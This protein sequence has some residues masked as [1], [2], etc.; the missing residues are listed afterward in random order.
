[1]PST[2]RQIFVRRRIA[3]FGGLALILGTGLYLPFTL[4]APLQPVAAQAV[5]FTAPEQAVP[6]LDF[7]GFG[8]AG[9]GAV[10]YPGVL[11][12]SGPTTPLPIASITKVITALVVLDA[13]P[14]AVDEA[15]PGVTFSAIDT[16]YY[17]TSL[18][19]EGIVKPVHAGQVTSERDVLNLVLMASASNYARSLA[20]WAFDTDEA[21]LTAA[22]AWLDRQGLDET[23]IAGPTGIEPTNT[24]T[25]AD[26]LRLAKIALRHPVVAQIVATA[27][28][29]IA[30]VGGVANR[31]QLLGIDGVDGIKTGTLDEAGSC[32]LFS[33]DATVG[34]QTISLVGV[35]LGGPD[36][37]TVDASVRVLLEQAVAGFQE[38]T[39]AKA[40]ESFATYTTSWGDSSSAVAANNASVVVWSDTPV[41]REVDTLDVG[42]AKAGSDAGQLTFRVGNR[43]IRV[44]LRLSTTIDDPG[45]WW[46]LTN[47]GSMF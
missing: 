3:V 13:K 43:T 22:R 38:V 10:G 25:V 17:R 24:S 35:V 40:G 6:V 15:G 44:P 19:E 5:P 32:L 28:V 37:P 41:A 36:H 42:I 39:L 12:S 47:P 11:A 1:M 23:T 30:G 29:E 33:A 8:A 26:L 9:I 45:P 18:A 34:S 20:H 14:L 2:P 7:P 4:L 16:T 46:R 27:Q 31:N 21:F